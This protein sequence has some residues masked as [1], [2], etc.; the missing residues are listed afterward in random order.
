MKAA[1]E[2]L[3]LTDHKV[4]SSQLSSKA[5]VATQLVVTALLAVP[6]ADSCVSS[7]D[8]ARY[9]RCKAKKLWIAALRARKPVT[10]PLLCICI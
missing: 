6:L 2:A 8:E 5:L 1:S 4:V 9:N 10:A 7:P 3:P